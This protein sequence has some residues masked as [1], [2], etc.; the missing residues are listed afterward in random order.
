MINKDE[1]PLSAR[2]KIARLR[3]T[4][5]EQLPERIA[6]AHI[7][8]KQLRLNASDHQAAANLHRALHSLKGTGRSFGFTELGEAVE[9]GESLLVNLIESPIK[10]LSADWLEQLAQ[11]ID[12]AQLVVD[13]VCS[14][15]GHY[16]TEP[17]YT[18]SMPVNHAAGSNDARL[19]YICDDEILV[20]EKLASQLRCF[21]YEVITF[22]DPNL[23]HDAA[24]TRKPDAIIMDIQF[25]QGSTIGTDILKRLKFDEGIEIPALFVSARND[26]KARLAAVQAGGDGYFHKPTRVMD[27]ITALDALTHQQ[28]LESY[29]ILI[30][31][32]EQEMASYHSIILQEAGMKTYQLSDPTNVLEILEYF[33]PDMV[34]MDMYMP[35]CSGRD[36]AK[37]IRQVPDHISLPIVY[38][39]SETDRQKQFAAMRIGAEGFLTKPVVPEDLVA[40][41]A[42][43]AERMRALRQLMSR[44]SLTGLFN[45]T[46]TTQLLEAAISTAGRAGTMLCFVMI[47]IDKFKLVNDTHGHPVGD[48][49]ILALSRVLQQR[50]RHSDIVG[51]YGGEE[52][53]VILQDINSERATW[54]IDE[55]RQDF[56]RVVFHS[57]NGEFSCS[58]SAGIAAFPAHNS[59]ESLREMADKALYIAKN[60]GRNCVIV[61]QFSRVAK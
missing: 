51:R 30:I 27:L 17:G 35:M 52:F 54:L 42:I 19:I 48:Q 21:G 40:A 31:D 22:A 26:F 45:H 20:L 10:P 8:L 13:E 58:F 2:E 18:L 33:R 50:L 53:A 24:L 47:D 12:H 32:D 36:L 3:A 28:Q 43:C 6:Q 61:D 29:R 7:M 5:I 57:D 38:L 37:L 59:V 25:P 44:D 11:S 4:F 16:Y 1:L 41:V 56:A 14:G 60:S 23:L 34:L 49:V 39:S 55:L 9:E 15:G 46:T